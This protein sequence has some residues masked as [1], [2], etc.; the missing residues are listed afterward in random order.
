M[1]LSD[2]SRAEQMLH[3]VDGTVKSCSSIAARLENSASDKFTRAVFE[4]TRPAFSAALQFVFEGSGT[5][6]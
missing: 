3:H 1:V 4:F 6:E 5:V 2:A